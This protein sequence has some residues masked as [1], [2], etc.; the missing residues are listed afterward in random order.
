MTA[1]ENPKVEGISADFQL[2]PIGLESIFEEKLQRRAF[3]ARF[4][5]G[6]N[7]KKF[8]ERYATEER[9]AAAQNK[10]LDTLLLPN[11]E[12]MT[13]LD[14][15]SGSGLHSYSAWR[16]GAKEVISFDYDIDSVE[17]TKKLWKMAGSPKNWSIMRGDVLDTEFMKQF[18]DID[19]IYSWGVLHH[20]GNMWKA[21]KNAAIPLEDRPAGVF[22]IA[23]YSYNFHQSVTMPPP[24]YWLA[25]KKRYNESGILMKRYLELQYIKQTFFKGKGLK[26]KFED[27]KRFQN[28]RKNVLNRGMSL[29]TDIRDWV[30]GWPMEFVKEDELVTFCEQRLHL[31][32][33]RLLTRRANTEMVFSKGHTWLDPIL[34]KRVHKELPKPFVAQG[35]AAWSTRL[36][37]Y[38][39][40]ADSPQTPRRSPLLL[41][42]DGKPLAYPHAVLMDI[43][44]YGH[45]RYSH[46]SINVLNKT[47]QRILFSASDNTNPNT[48]GRRYTFTADDPE[49]LAQLRWKGKYAPEDPPGQVSTTETAS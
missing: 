22:F 26:E 43:S 44:Q 48:N 31:K 45:G 49:L 34:G 8:V 32:L 14:I 19:I 35:N 21:I 18:K 23:L 6:K 2:L 47:I 20:T 28:A 11:L 3:M 9:L 24:E 37:E 4:G 38:S 41:W 39:D 7:W 1:A 12:G 10:L 27:W 25:L 5:F 13:F 33:V 29:M 42:E 15:G 40:L 16:A 46:H 30:G 17:T 36:P